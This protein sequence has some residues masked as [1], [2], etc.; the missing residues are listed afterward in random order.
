MHPITLLTPD[1][2]LTKY[3]LPK[4]HTQ[5]DDGE[6]KSWNHGGLFK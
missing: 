4:E 2:R 5:S 6:H 3:P 1:S